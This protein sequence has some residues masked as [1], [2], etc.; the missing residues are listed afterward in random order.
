M[1]IIKALLL[2]AVLIVLVVAISNVFNFV[3]LFPL[4]RYL[5]NPT[6]QVYSIGFTEYIVVLPLLLLVGS[7]MVY[8]NVKVAKKSIASLVYSLGSMLCAVL[9]CKLGAFII[10]P[11][12]LNLR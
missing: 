9:G 6:M 12:L 10:I 2:Y 1:K 11:M 8:Y 7:V 3:I 4:T 5:H